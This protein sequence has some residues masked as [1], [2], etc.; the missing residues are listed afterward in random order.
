MSRQRRVQGLIDELNHDLARK[1]AN[2][3]RYNYQAARAA[4]PNAAVMRQLFR[5]EAAE[6]LDHAAVLAESIVSLGGEPTTI[7][8]EFDK[9]RCPKLMLEVDV[10]L[11]EADMRRYLQHA[12]LAGDLEELDLQARLERI[13]EAEA[14]HAQDIAR[15]LEGLWPAAAGPTH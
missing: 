10:L 7:P 12:R 13:A 3:I 6:E 11:E 5:N 8:A 9:P 4:G 2:I 15:V 14:C 1:L